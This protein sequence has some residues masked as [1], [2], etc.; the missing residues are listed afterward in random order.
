MTEA[1]ISWITDQVATGGDFSFDPDKAA[2]QMI[3]L[4]DMNIDLVIDCRIEENDAD[5]WEY[6]GVTYV[7]LPV[8]DDGAKLPY[9]HFARAVQHASPVL[10]RGGK[11]F[12]HCHM[13]VNRGPS[14]AFALLLDQKMV[15]TK[16]FDLIRE[17]RPQAAVYYAMDALEA[18]LI[19]KK[20]RGGLKDRRMAALKQHIDTVFTRKDWNAIQHIIRSHHQRDAEE[21][22]T[23]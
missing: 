17:K 3:E 1:N 12:V 18:H 8:N 14:T 11:V 16:A 5:L 2:R 23:V 6:T 13:G 4:L 19:R 10:A 15:A 21:R 9:R 20:C 7:H 22:M